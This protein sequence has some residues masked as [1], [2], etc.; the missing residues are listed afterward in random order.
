MGT[1]KEQKIR[2]ETSSG[3]N[4]EEINRMVKDAEV[5]AEA[6]RKMK[7][8]TETRNEADSMVYSL[9]KLLEDNKDSIPEQEAQKVRT[10]IDNTKKALEGDDVEAIKAAKEK[11]QQASHSISQHIYNQAGAQTGAQ[12]GAGEQ[13]GT[14]EGQTSQQ[15]QASSSEEGDNVV[16]AEYEVVDDDKKDS[17]QQ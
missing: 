12:A 15:G 5:N 1:G 14:G 17:N 4:E 6:D 2:I 8:N 3:L 16:D 7:E 10:E 11:L 13:G 9:E